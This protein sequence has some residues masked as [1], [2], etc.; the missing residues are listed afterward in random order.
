MSTDNLPTS[1]PC[2]TCGRRIGWDGHGYAPCSA[3]AVIERRGEG[4]NA[5]V[6]AASL[7]AAWRADGVPSLITSHEAYRLTGGK[8]GRLGDH[9]A[10]GSLNL[11]TVARRI[12]GAR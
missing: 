2:P 7:Y 11:S 3:P 4:P 6:R 5:R 10:S 9:G 8:V 1:G 12:E